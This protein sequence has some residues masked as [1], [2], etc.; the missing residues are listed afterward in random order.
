MRRALRILAVLAGLAAV[1][2]IALIFLVDGMARA[3]VEK[4]ATQAL[5][6]PTSVAQVDIGLLSSSCEIERLVVNNPP[7]FRADHFLAV[8]RIHTALS[9]GS[10]LED[11]IELPVLEIE[12]ADM[13]LEQRGTNSNYAVILDNAKKGGKESGDEPGK[14]FVIRK[15][16]IRD[17]SVH[18][19][20]RLPGVRELG[21]ADI[22]IPAL[23][24]EDVGTG[25][26]KGVVLSE[27]AVIVVRAILDEVAKRGGA[28]IPPGALG[29][30]GRLLEE[31]TGSG[32]SGE[33]KIELNEEAV[34]KAAE[35][36]RKAI[37]E[38]VK[39]VEEG[40]DGG[41]APDPPKE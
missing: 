3:A 7:G 15:L 28:G 32:G 1:L 11:T 35:A 2:V 19:S 8:G 29:D 20:A 31:I 10:L 36:S 25:A 14:K 33:V 41:G 27:L 37:E 39:S 30:L 12:Q 24:L 22:T 13:H 21:K 18:V 34:K 16:S 17:V 40:A 6:V 4:S 38:A 23:T 5:G 26:E 9:L